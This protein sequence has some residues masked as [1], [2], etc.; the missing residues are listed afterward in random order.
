MKNKKGQFWN[1]ISNEKT[2]E[3]LIYGD[4][5]AEKFFDTDVAL[6]EFTE[7]LEALGDVPEI[8]VRI[9]SGGGDVFTATAISNKLKEHKAKIAVKIDGWAASAAT[10]IAMAG[11]TREIP[12]NGVF[13]VHDPST[14]MWGHVGTKEL[15]KTGKMLEAAKESIAQGYLEATGKT[16]EEIYSIMSAETWYV[17]KEAVDDGFC[18]TVKSEPVE[19]VQNK[20]GIVTNSVKVD[21]GQYKN[22]PQ[23]VLD[24][25]EEQEQKPAPQ[26][27]AKEKPKKEETEDE[28]EEEKGSE[29]MEPK[30]VEDLKSCFP[31]L[32]KQL[33]ENVAKEERNRI[34]DIE[35][36]TL[37]GFEDIA[38]KAKFESGK[39]AADVAVETQKRIKAQ[40]TNWIADRAQDVL[41]GNVGNEGAAGAHNSGEVENEATAL[42]QRMKKKQGGV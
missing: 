42:Y 38:T 14:F 28:D 40:G 15:E 8:V 21:P 35:E 36:M 17:G 26:A 30:T 29:E 19:H 37:A 20:G 7:N 32:T 11:D 22:I 18:D 41:D 24:V 4:I 23:K 13:M 16:V 1:F 5:V 6:A 25:L 12:V 9:N 2:P 3:I 10:I 31:E 27:K 34:K 33:M 39:T